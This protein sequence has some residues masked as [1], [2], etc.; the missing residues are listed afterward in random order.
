[1]AKKEE[2]K[3]KNREF[4]EE[5][6]TQDGVIR[7]PSGLLYKVLQK[8]TGT[9]CPNLRSIVSVHYKGELINGR[10]F[11]NS[12]ERNCPEALRLSEVIDGWQIALQMMH[13]GDRWMVYI[14]YELGYGTRSSSPIP[15]YST[16]IFEIELFSIA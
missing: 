8:G 16:L 5:L 4:L 11:D 13:V 3:L 1:M 6:A 2:Y 9:Q 15:G 7:H 12:W 14:P 10:V